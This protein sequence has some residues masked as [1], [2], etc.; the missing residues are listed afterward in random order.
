MQRMRTTDK[1]RKVITD[2]IML[3]EKLFR[4]ASSEEEKSD[5]TLVLAALRELLNEVDA[6][7]ESLPY[8]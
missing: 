1:M 4:E 3:H 5:H 8:A 2:K 6:F 7:L